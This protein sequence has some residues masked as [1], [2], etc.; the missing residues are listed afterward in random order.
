MT[1]NRRRLE[2]SNEDR[3][4]DSIECDVQ[5]QKMSD[6]SDDNFEVHCNTNFQCSIYELQKS[7]HMHMK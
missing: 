5:K 1:Q 6:D 2:F 3:A 4:R 7:I